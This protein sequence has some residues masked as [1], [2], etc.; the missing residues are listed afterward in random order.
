M[1]NLLKVCTHKIAT[2]PLSEWWAQALTGSLAQMIKEQGLWVTKPR[3][4][5]L[6]RCTTFW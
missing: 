4:P 6:S 2:Q 1:S 5:L 3:V